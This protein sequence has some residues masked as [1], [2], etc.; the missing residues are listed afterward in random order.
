MSCGW[1]VLMMYSSSLLCLAASSLWASSSV[2]LAAIQIANRIG[3]IPIA[4]TRTSIKRQ[5]LRDAGAADVI[6]SVE[7][8][9]RSRLENIVGSNGVR[10]SHMS[11]C[12]VNP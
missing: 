9:I 4:V 6:A 1:L 7:E 12:P 10:L 5:A 8:D 11:T 3:A 2:G